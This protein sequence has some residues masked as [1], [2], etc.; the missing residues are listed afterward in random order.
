[1]K[2]PVRP[3]GDRSWYNMDIRKKNLLVA[4]VV[5]VFAIALYVYSMYRVASYVPGP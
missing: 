3:G 4:I 1:M 5:A 2:I